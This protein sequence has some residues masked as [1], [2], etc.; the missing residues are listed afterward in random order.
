MS[1]NVSRS[2]TMAGQCGIPTNADAVSLIVTAVL[3]SAAGGL[4]LYPAGTALPGTTS[5]MFNA[6]KTRANNGGFGLGSGGALA[7]YVDQPAGATLH[8]V[9]DVNGYYETGAVTPPPS[10]T[11][12]HIWS[13]DF[14]GPGGLDDAFPLSVA[15]DGLGEIAMAGYFQNSVNLG[16]GILS[17]AGAGDIFVAKYS[18]QGT[19]L[20]A[21]RVGGLQD[22]RAKAVAVDGSGNVFITG[23]FYGTVDFG[24]GAVSS[25]PN[26][27]NCFVAKYSPTGAHLWSKRLSTALGLDEGMAIA[28]DSSGNVLV[29][30]MLYQTSNF[31]GSNLTSAGSADA[32]VVKLSNAGAHLWSKHAGGTA[33][34]SVFGLAVDS[35][36]NP[37]ITGHSTGSADFGGGSLAGAGGKDIFVAQY[38]GSTGAHLWSKRVG[39]SGDDMGRG[40]AIDGAGEVAVT[41]N[42]GSSSV[43]FGS[44]ELA[45]S[46]GADIFLAKY[47]SG[48]TAL[49]SKRFGAGLSLDEKAFGIGRDLSGNILLTGSVVDAI[50]FGGG[51]LPGDGYYDIFVAKFGS[52][53][54]HVWSKRTGAGAGTSLAAD[55][56]G[57]V[58]LAGYFIGTTPVSF[59]GANLLSPG[60]T[61]AFLV[62]FG[63]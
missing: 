36:G 58:V 49:W 6:S 39:G 19:P 27:V 4:R 47:S 17:S 48:G 21:R 61:D 29:G 54:G 23:L 20:W 3:P 10:G 38:S 28:T 8:L 16:T 51:S 13:A 46:G 40:I 60:G 5:L 11:G 32:F 2:F 14:G 43:N 44:G 30:G 9:M 22:D 41:G 33:E 62:K 12:P 52:A 59:G 63:P 50:D 34:E 55:G 31:G 56:A 35:N 45:N 26:A 57:N 37:A 24:G 1:A 25:A 53:G 15:V 7:V 18:A 42:F